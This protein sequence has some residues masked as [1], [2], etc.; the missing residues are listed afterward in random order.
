MIR[1]LRGELAHPCHILVTGE[2]VPVD[3][4]ALEQISRNAWEDRVSPATLEERCY[5][6]AEVSLINSTTGSTGLP[7]FAEYPAAGR[8]LYGQ[9]YIEVLELCEQDVVAALS[10]AA[11]GPN[12][13]VYFAA[14][15]AGA[16]TVFLRH[17]KAEDAF[18]LIQQQKV[19]LACM[20]PAQLAMMVRHPRPDRFDL[21]SM[22]FWLSVGAPLPSNLAQEAEEK[23]GGVVLNTY[24]AADWGGVVFT[25]PLD[26]P[27]RRY[28]TVGKPR[29]GTEVRLADEKGRPVGSGQVGE[30]QGRGPACSSGYY[31]DPEATRNAW[32]SDGWMP[33]GDLARWDKNGSLVIVG[34]KRDVIIRGGQNVEPVEIENYLLVHPKVKHV[35]VVGMPDPVMGERIC[36]YV[37][38]RTK[39]S[40]T[41]EEIVMFLRLKK[42]AS[43]KLPE[44]LELV[45]SLPMVS[46]TKVNKRILARTIKEKL[47]KDL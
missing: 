34:R 9:S 17:F 35:A 30:I 8:L 25:S 18:Q 41:L 29:V 5:K 33:L 24:G 4:V 7:K 42:I 31:R 20:G 39:E 21:S 11:A 12:I 23:L 22:R 37:V 27:E 26:P 10:P 28:F 45:E 44:R 1:D 38:P 13:P 40:P 36:A 6:A 32:T 15:Q 47:G 14:P 3:G 16:K 46:D 19:T 43:Y 2:N